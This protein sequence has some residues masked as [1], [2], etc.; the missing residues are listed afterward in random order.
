MHIYKIANTI[1]NHVERKNSKQDFKI[2]MTLYILFV[3][4]S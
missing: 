2:I 4:Y 3:T 1:Q